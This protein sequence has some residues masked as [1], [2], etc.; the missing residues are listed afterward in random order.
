MY[1]RCQT[2]HIKGISDVVLYYGGSKFT[3]RDY[4]DSNFADD[5]KK[6]ITS[7]YIFIIA[8]GAVRWVSKLQVIV[9]LST[10]ETEY[11]ATIQACKEAYG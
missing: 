4:V 9:V 10:T 1:L 3:I 6:K 8:R 2:L 5:L 11:M 7:G